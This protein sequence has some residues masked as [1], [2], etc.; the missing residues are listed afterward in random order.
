M[1]YKL[2]IKYVKQIVNTLE[3]I[4][5]HGYIHTDIK[6]ENILISHIDDKNQKIIDYMK[7]KSVEEIINKR[8]IENSHK[9]QK[10]KTLNEKK[11]LI[12]KDIL[13]EFIDDKSEDSDSSS[14]N[15]DSYIDETSCEVKEEKQYRYTRDMTS[16]D[17]N[18][19]DEEDTFISDEGIEEKKEN[20][21]Y[22][23]IVMADF[24]TIIR[25]V[26]KEQTFNIQTRYYRSPEVILRIEYDNRIDIWSLGCMIYELIT[27]D[28]L[29]YP[30]NIKEINI[31][32]YH[33]YDIQMKLGLIEKD[34][35]DK[36]KTRDIYLR[37]DGGIRGI[38]NIKPDF[39]WV[40]I[41]DKLKDEYNADEIEN[42]MNLLMYCLEV[43]HN[44]R[45]TSKQLINIL[46]KF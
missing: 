9:I 26:S 32:R 40:K 16:I 7:K 38:N 17:I 8:F 36:C 34:I 11:N 12:I 37:E 23:N 24:G 10:L 1:P 19:D 13:L 41:Y 35:W 28:I 39:L 20:R 33:I 21:Y 2:L 27:G 44:K 29:F 30:D 22:E 46:D 42:I 18:S 43:D 4:H 6:P 15:E 3:N 14:E 5:A 31:D 25:S 45:K